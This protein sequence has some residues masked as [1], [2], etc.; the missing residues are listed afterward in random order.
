MAQ[1]QRSARGTCSPTPWANEH[2]ALYSWTAGVPQAGPGFAPEA[3]AVG[4]NA[5]AAPACDVNDAKAF[6]WNVDLQCRNI[7]TF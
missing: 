5:V 7:W 4:L 3:I 2:T 1:T 6:K